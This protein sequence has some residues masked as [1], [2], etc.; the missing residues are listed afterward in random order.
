MVRQRRLD[1]ERKEK[2]PDFIWEEPVDFNLPNY[3][4]NE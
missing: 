1:M 4:Y 2:D 3:T